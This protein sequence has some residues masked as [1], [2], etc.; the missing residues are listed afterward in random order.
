MVV[1]QCHTEQGRIVVWTCRGPVGTVHTSP[2]AWQPWSCQSTVIFTIRRKQS[3]SSLHT[4]SS[5]ATGLVISSPWSPKKATGPVRGHLEQVSPVSCE[6]T[7]G[8]IQWG[9]GLRLC[10][11]TS[12][13]NSWDVERTSKSWC[14]W[15]RYRITC[16]RNLVSETVAKTVW[17][18]REDDVG[19]SVT[20]VPPCSDTGGWSDPAGRR[21][22][23]QSWI[24][25]SGHV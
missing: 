6:L 18:L 20:T 8:H 23:H 24:T 22:T 9:R 1:S 5:S 16:T 7:T 14:V 19:P 2:F 10:K 17:S 13:T 3:L 15:W 4:G 11:G 25:K 12:K 21:W